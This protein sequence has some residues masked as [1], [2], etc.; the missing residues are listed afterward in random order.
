VEL[1][2]GQ[3]GHLG[4]FGSQSSISQVFSKEGDAWL[5]AWINPT[6]PT[7]RGSSKRIEMK[8]FRPFFSIVF[9]ITYTFFS[10]QQKK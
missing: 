5:T 9:R 10:C 1:K 4:M 8:I 7:K 6:S 3:R 2:E